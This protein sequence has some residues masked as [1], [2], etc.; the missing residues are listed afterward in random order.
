M[1]H[2]P[3][4]L[5]NVGFA[6]LHKICFEGF[7]AEIH[8]GSRIAVIGRNGSGKS[9]L[10]KILQRTVEPHE[11]AISTPDEVISGFVPQVIEDF[12]SLSGGQR[13]SKAMTRALACGPN[14]LLLDEP[15]N[16]LD[17]NNRR[18]LMR[19]LRNFPGTLIIVSHDVE[20]LRTCV[21]TLW[22][23]DDGE[24]HVFSGSYDE[25]KNVRQKQREVLDGRLKK[26]E[27]DK[28]DSHVALMR[29]QERG[30][31]RQLY[32]EKKY[33]GD[34]LALRG[35]Q[36]RGELTANKNKKAIACEKESILKQ[37][38]SL[39]L[40]EIIKPKFSLDASKA[41]SKAVVFI[42]GGACG[43]G[44]AIL[45]GI[46]LSLGSC[47]R[48]A[49]TGNNGSGKSTL[50]RAIMNDCTVTRSGRWDAPKPEDIGL[51]DQHYLNLSP[52][53]TVINI[54]QNKVPLW[55]HADIRRHLNDFLFR[56]N[57]ETAA[58]VHTL[59]GGEKARLSLALIAAKPPKLL[60]LDEIT[61]NLDLESRAHVIQV[62]K[63]YPGA[64]IV[65]S[66]DQDFLNALHLT[67]VIECNIKIKGITR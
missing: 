19:M 31:K 50:I 61:N 4:R 6:F 49:V 8:Y 42:S 62:L 43:Y 65:I 16:H 55:L 38:A 2:R 37:A 58:P 18:S 41:S 57:E 17:L 34:K 59:S 36:G 45:E 35:A 21:D 3:I 54:L 25:Y 32:G 33:D 7:S 47:D 52:D 48:I 60:I 66:H 22:H 39:R 67:G 9:T 26:L 27:R 46:S 10:L 56:K 11:G 24:V 53:L 40:P 64:M 28:A 12:A 29:E 20:L 15:T 5:Q 51:V 63:G 30:K 1:I 14:L 23:I 13:L 44:T